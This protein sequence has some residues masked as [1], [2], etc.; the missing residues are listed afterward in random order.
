[1]YV[2]VKKKNIYIYI[3]IY[4]RICVF[5]FVCMYVC[6]FLVLLCRPAEG[7]LQSS[8]LHPFRWFPP[9]LLC[10]LVSPLTLRCLLLYMHLLWQMQQSPAA[11]YRIRPAASPTQPVLSLSRATGLPT[12][13]TS[14]LVLRV[15]LHTACV[16]TCS[17]SQSYPTQITKYKHTYIHTYTHTHTHTHTYIHIHK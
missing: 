9:L 15:R 14:C 3:Y 1:M 7:L 10:W 2:R 13:F 6:I 4:A 12:S 8:P 16:T 11:P 5:V 17:C